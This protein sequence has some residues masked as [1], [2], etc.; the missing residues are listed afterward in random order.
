MDGSPVFGRKRHHG[1]QYGPLGIVRD[2]DSFLQ[3][4][5][6][7]TAQEPEAVTAGVGGTLEQPGLLPPGF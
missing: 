5:G 6:F 7:P 3:G 1:I 4:G 2:V